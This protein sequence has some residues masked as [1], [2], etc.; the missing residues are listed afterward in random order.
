MDNN[1]ENKNKKIIG[2]CCLLIIIIFAFAMFTGNNTT[3]ENTTEKEPITV[4]ELDFDRYGL[5]FDTSLYG[6]I[7]GTDSNGKGHNFYVT[8]DQMAGLYYGSGKTFDFPDGLVITYHNVHDGTETGNDV[9]DH[10]YWPNGTEISPVGGE[11]SDV[12]AANSVSIGKQF[13]VCA[14]DFGMTVSESAGY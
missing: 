13:K 8:K 7:D 10:I 4:K 1:N 9:V 5:A 6:W 2:G 12:F 14:E 3:H 11:D